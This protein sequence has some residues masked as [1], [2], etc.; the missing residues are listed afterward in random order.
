MT[1]S[2]HRK[3]LTKRA[4]GMTDGNSNPVPRAA[5]SSLRRS[6]KSVFHDEFLDEES[7]K[8][9]KLL[10]LGRQKGCITVDDILYSGVIL[11]VLWGMISTVGYIQYCGGISSIV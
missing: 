3:N 6:A 10:E 1:A 9:Q 4:R 7:P 2:I 8:I 11:K 5:P